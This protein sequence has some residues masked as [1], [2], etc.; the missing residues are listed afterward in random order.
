MIE[1]DA[2]K[3]QNI[4]LNLVGNSIKHTNKGFIKIIIQKIEDEEVFIQD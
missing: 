3:I 1:S 4:V 2:Y